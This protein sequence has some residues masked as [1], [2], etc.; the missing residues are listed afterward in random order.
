MEVKDWLQTS[1]LQPER[2]K[3]MLELI[4]LHSAANVRL[5]TEFTMRQSGGGSFVFPVSPR[6]SSVLT[7]SPRVDVL[8]PV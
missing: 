7:A 8:A 1:L 2:E 5:Q 4:W 3:F 6:L